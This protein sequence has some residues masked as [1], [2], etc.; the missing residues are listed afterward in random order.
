[1]IFYFNIQ[2]TEKYS[3]QRCATSAQVTPSSHL[4]PLVCRHYFFI[5]LTFWLASPK[6]WRYVIKC[7][8][9]PVEFWALSPILLRISHL[10]LNFGKT[11]ATRTRM[12]VIMMIT[13][14]FPFTK[15]TEMLLFLTKHQHP[16]VLWKQRHT[17]SQKNEWFG[18]NTKLQ[19]RTMMMFQMATL[20][21]KLS[22]EG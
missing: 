20:L 2:R 1:M 5:I 21:G 9:L 16:N 18:V 12:V 19:K 13:L 11:S 22:W 15:F 6:K 3:I 8:G 10:L 7:H 17:S 14:S 4:L